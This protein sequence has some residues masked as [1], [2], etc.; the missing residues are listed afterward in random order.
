MN[1]EVREIEGQRTPWLPFTHGTYQLVIGGREASLISLYL[2]AA[3][4]R[5]LQ[6]VATPMPYRPPRPH[7]LMQR[8]R[9][10]SARTSP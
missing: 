7:C 10:V 2:K 8:D 9:R 3:G 1:L 4:K 6:A 5:L